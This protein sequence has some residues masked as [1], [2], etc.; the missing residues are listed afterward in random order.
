MKIICI[1]RNY[2]EHAKELGNDIP[3]EPVIFMKPKSAIIQPHTPFYYPEFTNVI[4]GVVRVIHRAKVGAYIKAVFNTPDGE[5]EA[6]SAMRKGNPQ[7]RMALHNTSKNER[8]NGPAGFCGHTYQPG[9]PILAHFLFAHH[10]PGVYKNGTAKVFS[11]LPEGFKH[12]VAE[13]ERID[14]RANFNTRH[15]QF[16]HTTL[17]FANGDIDVLHRHCAEAY[18]PVRLLIYAASNMVVEK[19]GSFQRMFGFGEVIKQHGNGGE[20]LHIYRGGVHFFGA[21]VWVPAILLYFAEYFIALY[22][23]GTAGFVVLQPYEFAIAI[24]LEPVRD[25]LRH[26]MGV[27]IYLHL[28]CFK[29][30]KDI[31]IARTASES[32]LCCAPLA[33]R[34]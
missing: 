8:A 28:P 20:H 27:D 16:P 17:H 30:A 29:G 10:L 13:V 11:G 5:R 25:M 14:V 12:R 33:A 6:A 32:P 18:K 24:F 21:Y 1:G 22:H 31:P 4:A 9:Q 7:A 3:D 23:T 2:V 15:V 19:P 26:Y 34:L